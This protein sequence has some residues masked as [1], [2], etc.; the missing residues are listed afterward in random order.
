[1][2]N[3]INYEEEIG[4][5][6]ERLIVKEI[7][8]EKGKKAIAVCECDCGGIKRTQLTNLRAGKTMSCGCLSN[9]E[10]HKLGRGATHNMS[11]SKIYHIFQNMIARCYNPNHISYKNYGKRG[12]KVCK[13]WLD[14]EKGFENFYKWS[15]ANGY[16]EE[17]YKSGYSKLSIDRINNNKGYSPSN[18]RWVYAKVQNYNKRTSFFNLEEIELIESKGF[19]GEAIKQRMKKYNFTLEE[20]ISI[21]LH[22]KDLRKY[23][24]EHPVK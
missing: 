20:A 12:I 8:R 15:I 6:Y 3:K 22:T 11:N 17:Y 18:C 7:I 21:P 14:K 5:R 13:K 1:M 10:R 9:E 23:L 19:Q 16:K 2:K 4:K 24:K